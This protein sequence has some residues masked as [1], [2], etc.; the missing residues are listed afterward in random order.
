VPSM[1]QQ[2]EYPT[3]KPGEN[4]PYCGEGPL[5]P[6]PSGMNLHCHTCNKITVLPQVQRT[7]DRPDATRRGRIRGR[8]KGA[9]R[10]RKFHMASEPR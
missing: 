7:D 4:C 2:A 5:V 6:S 10:K 3:A 8:P 1:T 9:V